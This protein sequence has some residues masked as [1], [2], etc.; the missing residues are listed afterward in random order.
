[1]LTDQ[2]LH[3]CMKESYP[4]NPSNEFISSTEAILRESAR[5]MNKKRKIKRFTI[6]SSTFLLT[7]LVISWFF[8]FSGQDVFNSNANYIS[9]T[10][11]GPNPIIYIYHTHNTES[12]L[13]ELDEQKP[14]NASHNQKNITLVGKYF[15]LALKQRNINSIQDQSDITAIVKERNLVF[16]DMYTISRESFTQTIKDN[17]SI[18]M[19]FDIHRDSGERDNTAVR[20]NG[21]E[22]AK[23]FFTVS[24]STHDYKEN[25]KLAKFLHKKIEEK[26]PGL[27]RGVESLSKGNGH[28]GIYNQDLMS[29][30]LLLNIGGQNNTFEETY[31]TVDALADIISENIETLI[32]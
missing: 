29:K 5:K 24:K 11:T 10:A 23:I 17:P 16:K 32:K 15:S 9:S 28:E 13:P 18:K 2:D 27:S 4:L 25:Y 26:Y 31:R 22:Y 1:M 19:A 21:K 3:N 14:F 6:T 7:A 8:F 12:F 20:I 30:T